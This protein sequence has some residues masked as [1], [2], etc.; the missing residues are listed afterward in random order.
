LNPDF[1]SGLSNPDELP[2]RRALRE[3]EGTGDDAFGMENL[4]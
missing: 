1:E 4:G 2:R 3:D